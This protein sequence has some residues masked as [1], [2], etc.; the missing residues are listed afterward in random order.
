MTLYVVQWENIFRLT[1]CV[2]FPEKCRVVP[3]LLAPLQ[4]KMQSK[5]RL[6][7]AK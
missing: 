2:L 4:T 7:A 6:C 3:K 5:S 1:S